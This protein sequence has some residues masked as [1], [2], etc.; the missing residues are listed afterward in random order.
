MGSKFGPTYF[1]R[2]QLFIYLSV[3]SSVRLSVCLSVTTAVSGVRGAD[4]Q[5]KTKGPFT[6]FAKKK[7]AVFKKNL[8]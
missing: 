6:F 8:F 4:E 2:L 7:Q 5:E 1:V 3:R